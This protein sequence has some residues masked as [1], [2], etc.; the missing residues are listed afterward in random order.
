MTPTLYGRWQTRLLLLATVGILITLPFYLGI[1]GPGFNPVFLWILLYV[2]LF[3]LAWDVLYNYIQKFR[4]DR[5]WPGALQLLSGIWEGIFLALLVKLI[6]LPNV[7]RG[8]PLQW[9]FIHYSLVWLSIYLASQS[10]MRALFPRW[11][12]KGGQ[13]F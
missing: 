3:G 9:F 10:L 11:R 4:W 5:D 6:G 1:V 8:L 2:A 12:F 7:S 13:W